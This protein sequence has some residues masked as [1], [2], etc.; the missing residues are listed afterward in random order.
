MDTTDTI[1]IS[2]NLGLEMAESCPL[3]VVCFTD[4][5]DKSNLL[6]DTTINSTSIWTKILYVERAVAGILIMAN[7]SSSLLINRGYVIL[8]L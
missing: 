3:F 6:S 4:T 5:H 7:Y 1:T 2:H 8:D